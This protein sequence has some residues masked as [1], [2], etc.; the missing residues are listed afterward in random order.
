[1]NREG[2]LKS[3]HWPSLL[4][5][6][7]YFDVSFMIWVLIGATGVFISQDLQLTATQKGLMV[8]LPIL[9]GSVFRIFMGVLTD[10]IGAKRTAIAGML[11]TLLPLFM[12]W[13]FADSLPE[14]YA[15]GFVLGIAGASFAAALPM[16]SRWYPPRYQGLAMGIAGA[17]NSGTLLATLFAPRLAAYFGD[18]NPVFGLA[19]LPML[20]VLIFFL[21]FAKEPPNQ[22]APKTLAQSFSVLKTRDAWLFN[23]FYFV[24]FGGFVGMTSFL[25]IFFHDQYGLDNVQAGDFVTLCVLAGSLFRPVGGWISDKWGGVRVLKRLFLAIVLLLGFVSQLLPFWLELAGLFL[26]MV[27]YGLGNGAVFQLVPQ[28]FAGEIGTIT[29]LVGAFGG[30]GGFFL[31]SILGMAKEIAGTYSLGFVLLAAIVATA[32]WTMLVVGERWK[33]RLIIPGGKTNSVAQG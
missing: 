33:G 24:T 6:F 31:P 30:I 2:F 21:V 8:A 16:A 3:G 11:L 32:F 12:L 14:I 15:Y 9:G 18:W 13:L 10:R 28:R 4:A 25:S 23:F 22:P 5:S 20:V 27:C 1:M 17:G 26:L 19:M 29:G 7:L